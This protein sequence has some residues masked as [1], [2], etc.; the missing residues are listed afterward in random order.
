[1][2]DIHVRELI[3]IKELRLTIVLQLLGATTALGEGKLFILGW[4]IAVVNR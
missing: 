4:K 1:M 3:G 2:S